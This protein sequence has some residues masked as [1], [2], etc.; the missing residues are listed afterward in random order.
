[1]RNSDAYI[2]RTEQAIKS[3]RGENLE[4]NPYISVVMITI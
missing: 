1:M 4:I 3:I 2:I